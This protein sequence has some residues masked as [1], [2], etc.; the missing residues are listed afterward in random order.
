MLVFFALIY[1][2]VK[3]V[4]IMVI[5]YF[6]SWLQKNN[7]RFKQP[8]QIVSRASGTFY[9]DH[10]I[11]LKYR[12]ITSDLYVKV[13]KNCIQ[14]QVNYK[15]SHFDTI[16]DFEIEVEKLDPGEYCCFLCKDYDN[17]RFQTYK[18]ARELISAH[19]YEDFLEWSNE[20]ICTSNFLLYQAHE[21]FR[22]AMVKQQDEIVK[23]LNMEEEKYIIQILSLREYNTNIEK[24]SKMQIYKPTFNE[25]SK[26]ANWVINKIRDLAPL[27]N[28][29]L[30][31][32]LLFGEESTWKK[33][34]LNWLVE[35]SSFTVKP[36]DTFFKKKQYSEFL[37]NEPFEEGVQK[38]NQTALY[39]YCSIIFNQSEYDKIFSKYRNNM[40]ELPVA[41]WKE[42]FKE[43]YIEVDDYLSKGILDTTLCNMLIETYFSQ[44]VEEYK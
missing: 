21:G 38:I 15:D 37:F 16:C 28:M 7:H 18:T 13:Y 36:D 23:I 20:Y 12:G 2:F 40:N 35:I 32:I 27:I 25:R 41:I 39:K 26:S 5:K 4:N 11:Q 14:V 34:A 17:V 10:F 29:N 1:W 42:L 6:S 43:F 19:T 8:L 44:K 31:K 33:S 24:K 22:A 30:L 3:E 9:L